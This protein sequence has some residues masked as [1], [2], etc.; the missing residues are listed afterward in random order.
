MVVRKLGHHVTEEEVVSFCKEH[1]AHF[2]VPKSVVFADALPKN[3]SGKVLKRELRAR[4]EKGA[5]GGA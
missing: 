5:P 1:M 2:K 3:P 4:Y